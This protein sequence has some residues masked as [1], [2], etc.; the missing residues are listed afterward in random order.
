MKY[1]AQ[2]GQDSIIQQFFMG[3]GIKDGFYLDVG[4]LDGLRFSNTFMLEKMGWGGVCVEAHPSYYNLLCENRP[5]S[6][7]YSCAAGDRDKETVE[8]N[9]NFRASLTSLD[10]DQQEHFKEKYD[11]WYGDRE[12][13]E[14]NGFLNGRHPVQMRTLDS[15]LQENNAKKVNLVSIDIDGSE[16]Y[17]FKGLDLNK[18][19]VDLLVLE[20]SVVGKEFVD[21]YAKKFGFS[22]SRVV[23]A[24]VIYT[25]NRVDD[26]IIKSLNINGEFINIPHPCLR[27][28]NGKI[29]Q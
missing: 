17:A 28:Q 12:L 2:E 29:L 7:C 9:L 27:G 21:E 22:P 25:K 23:G 8:I 11:Q 20:W 5:N 16:K 19:D 24:D 6:L 1:Y 3:K 15:I 18:Y 4:S 10:F 14:I 26:H 13:K